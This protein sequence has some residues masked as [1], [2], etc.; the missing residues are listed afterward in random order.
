MNKRPAL[1]AMATLAGASILGVRPAMAAPDKFLHVQVMEAGKDGDNVNVNVPL[2]LA[3]KVLPTIDRG[4][5]H[6][7]RVDVP[8]DALQGIDLRTIIDAVK[9]TPDSHIVTAQQRDQDVDVEKSHGNIVVHVR[10]RNAKGQTVEVTVPISVV[11]ALFSGVNKDQLD[12]SAALQALD[13]AGDTFRVMVDDAR[14]HVRIWIDSQS[15]PQASTQ[16]QQ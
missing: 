13:T 12:V 2:A 16:S 6:R 10:Q 1:I 3:E 14:E 4:P 5:L 15:Q 11:D 8:N 9:T 7:G